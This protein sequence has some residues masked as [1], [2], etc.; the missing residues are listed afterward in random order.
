MSGSIVYRTK[1][2]FVLGNLEAALSEEVVP[3][4]AVNCR[5]ALRPVRGCGVTSAQR[6][7]RR[8]AVAVILTRPSNG[9]P[10][11]RGNTMIVIVTDGVHGRWGS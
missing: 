2:D 6:A 5:E 7:L 1:C 9:C 4:P 3:G 8:R 11:L 10:I